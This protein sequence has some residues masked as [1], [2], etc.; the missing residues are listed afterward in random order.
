[1][2]DE[3]ILG[4]LLRAHKETSAQMHGETYIFRNISAANYWEQA[5]SFIESAINSASRAEQ[6]VSQQD[7][8]GKRK[9]V[10]Q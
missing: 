1:M 2:S 7:G 5:T 6:Y 4:L 3:S 10:K 9:E 8:Q